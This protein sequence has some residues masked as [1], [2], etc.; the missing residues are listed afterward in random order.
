MNNDLYSQRSKSKLTHSNRSIDPP[1][2][3]SS[4]E[5]TVFCL[6]SSDSS[7]SQHRS[8]R[9]RPNPLPRRPSTQTT[10]TDYVHKLANLFTKSFSTTSPSP[11]DEQQIS[12]QTYDSIASSSSSVQT[13]VPARPH[14]NYVQSSMSTDDLHLPSR[15]REP[16]RN[17]QSNTS[18]YSMRLFLSYSSS[19]N[20]STIFP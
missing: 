17:E 14:T 19:R 3:P 1:S 7:S 15:D 18:L 8:S 20:V 11:S 10:P 16:V 9:R 4:P 12:T 6:R 5:N 13:L 2:I